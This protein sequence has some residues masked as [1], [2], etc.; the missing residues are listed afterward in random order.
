MNVLK[1]LLQLREAE[2]PMEL[3]DVIKFFPKKHGEALQKLWGGKRL[4]WHG[5][6]FFD[7][8]GLG[9]AYEKAEEAAKAYIAD[10]YNAEASLEVELPDGEMADVQWDA[11]FE[12]D[13]VQEVYL[14]YDPKRDVLFIGFDAWTSDDEFNAA[15]DR[16]W[17]E[18]TGEEHDMDND[19][20]QEAYNRIW[21]DYQDQ[22]MGFWGLCFEISADMKAEE[23][24]PPMPGGFYRGSFK[25]LKSQNNNLVDLR[26]D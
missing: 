9:E 13:E 15:F 18:E 5:M 19:E 22:N 7:D 26:L 6:R 16:T 2:V 10:G 4:V 20:H 17:E 3:A 24:L 23:A 25:L 14:G 1:E 12:D 11:L 21:K 8:G